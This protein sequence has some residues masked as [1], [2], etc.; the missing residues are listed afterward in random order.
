MQLSEFKALVLK[1]HE[2]K[3]LNAQ[4]PSLDMVTIQQ[5]G[6]I[7]CAVGAAYILSGLPIPEGFLHNYNV[8]DRALTALGIDLG[9]SVVNRIIGLHDAWH[10]T[11]R[12]G[13]DAKEI[14]ATEIEASFLELL[15]S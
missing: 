8:L 13:R 6:K 1:A 15:R 14:E 7:G 12:G 3:I 11:A 4:H 9:L 10:S 5:D 2:L